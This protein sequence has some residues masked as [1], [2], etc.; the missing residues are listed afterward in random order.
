MSN[1]NVVGSTKIN[2]QDYYANVANGPEFRMNI[3]LV[4]GD[5]SHLSLKCEDI[6]V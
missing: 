1:W 6:H 2:I 3:M 4:R 5:R